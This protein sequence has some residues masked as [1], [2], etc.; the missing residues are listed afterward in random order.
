[1]KYPEYQKPLVTRVMQHFTG[2][3]EIP[4]I[5]TTWDWKVEKLQKDEQE[6]RR[7]L[8]TI[9]SRYPGILQNFMALITRMEEAT[10][11]GGNDVFFIATDTVNDLVT[12]MRFAFLAQKSTV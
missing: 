9:A 6:A 11:D 4:N 10:H 3:D 12:A 8:Q 5:H 7:Y 2:I 1:M